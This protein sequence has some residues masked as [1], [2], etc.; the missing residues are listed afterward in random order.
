MQTQIPHISQSSLP[1][2]L[3][4]NSLALI[5]SI[6]HLSIMAADVLSPLERALTFG[7]LHIMTRKIYKLILISFVQKKIT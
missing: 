5:I 2:P 7:S 3:K 6:Y 4:L 1:I